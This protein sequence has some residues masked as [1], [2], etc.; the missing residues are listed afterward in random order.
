MAMPPLAVTLISLPQASVRVLQEDGTLSIPWRRAI[1]QLFTA[2][3]G[4]APN[5]AAIIAQLSAFALELASVKAIAETAAADAA[6]ALAN[7]ELALLLGLIAIGGVD[8]PLGDVRV[9]D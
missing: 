7:G 1:Q 4:S 2:A 8:G 5:I 9:I 3:G 6:L